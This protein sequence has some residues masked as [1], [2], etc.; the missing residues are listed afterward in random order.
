MDTIT[1][2]EHFSTPDLQKA[3][4][5]VRPGGTRDPALKARLLDLGQGRLADMDEGRRGHAGA[6][7]RC[8]RL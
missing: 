4:E 1:L 8:F 5:E 6:F 2:E 7:T 3:I